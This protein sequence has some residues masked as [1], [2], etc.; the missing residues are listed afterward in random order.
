[1]VELPL[2]HVGKE[3]EAGLARALGHLFGPAARELGQWLADK[4]RE[5][6]MG[7]FRRVLDR[8]NEL[9]VSP[10]LTLPSDRF[11]IGFAGAA[12]LE[13]EEGLIDYW[14]RLLID[15][16][17]NEK[18]QHIFFQDVI[19]RMRQPEAHLFERLVLQP[20]VPRGSLA[21]L[22]D[23]FRFHGTRALHEAGNELLDS[24]HPDR[25]FAA[26]AE[27][28]DRFG[29]QLIEAT[30]FSHEDGMASDWNDELWALSDEDH[31]SLGILQQLGVLRFDYMDDLRIG[32]YRMLAG[33]CCLTALGAEFFH[34]T[35]DPELRK[36]PEERAPGSY[37][38][39]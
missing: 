22:G 39:A 7:T 9:S 36:P 25:L 38:D 29:L 15:A 5:K 6:R 35:H 8:A 31:I 33:V 3:T 17:A 18:A 10:T 14:A 24:D 19:A 27:K 30:W 20:R 16:A 37:P 23:V 28:L 1:M 13:E 2:A 32:P 34:A 11:L 26:M 4:V 21:Q 12:S